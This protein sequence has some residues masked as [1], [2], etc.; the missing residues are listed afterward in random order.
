MSDK[1][2]DRPAV[3]R[4]EAIGRW[5]PFVLPVIGTVV[6]YL[7]YRP[8]LM[9]CAQIAITMSVVAQLTA[10]MR[11]SLATE[12]FTAF[13]RKMLADID[14][15]SALQDEH[16]RTFDTLKQTLATESMTD[17]DTGMMD[18][19]VERAAMRERL[20]GIIQDEPPKRGGR[21]ATQLTDDDLA[22]LDAA[23]TA[24]D[25]GWKAFN[26]YCKTHNLSESTMRDRIRRYAPQLAE[27]RAR[28]KPPGGIVA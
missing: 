16:E 28:N 17:A 22:Q 27:W 5:A 26:G 12:R 8:S 24:Y 13:G 1:A 20:T 9:E 21:P 4:T 19:L 6:I 15:M 11:D 2:P 18:I 3:S 14:R 23:Q 25:G 10:H 7:L